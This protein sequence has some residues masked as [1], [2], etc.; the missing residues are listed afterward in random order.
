LG[1]FEVTMKNFISIMLLS[2]I[3]LT[4]PVKAEDFTQNEYI[5]QSVECHVIK[6]AK[7]Y[8][9]EVHEE[10]HH[11]ITSEGL[12]YKLEGLPSGFDE[13]YRLSLS[14]IKLRLDARKPQFN[15]LSIIQDQRSSNVIRRELRKLKRQLKNISKPILMVN[16]FYRSQEKI[17]LTQDSKWSINEEFA[18]IDAAV[19]IV[20]SA[21]L[22]LEIAET[23]EKKEATEKKKLTL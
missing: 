9:Y 14:S 13:Q 7:Q 22:A 18:V 8:K 10:T 4:A 6:A 1:C 11:C 20:E 21:E 19:A 12:S 15:R 23:L 17:T 3:L 2:G 16:H 5:S